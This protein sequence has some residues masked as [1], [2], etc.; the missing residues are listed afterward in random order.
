MKKLFKIASTLFMAAF[1]AA[2][3]ISC[4]LGTH[5]LINPSAGYEEA[6]IA[7]TDI[8]VLTVKYQANVTDTV[9][10]HVDNYSVNIPA[11]ASIEEV[12]AVAKSIC[13][14]VAE[15]FEARTYNRVSGTTYEIGFFRKTVTLT[16]KTSSTATADL[17]TTLKGVY[18]ASF[19]APAKIELPEGREW[20]KWYTPTGSSYLN[21]GEATTFPASS[22]V[23]YPSYYTEKYYVVTYKTEIGTAP[24]PL[25]LKSGSKYPVLTAEQ[26]PVIENPVDDRPFLGWYIDNTKVTAGRTVTSNI[27]LTAKWGNF[28]TVTYIDPSN[29]AQT[30]DVQRVAAGTSLAGLLNP[31]TDP[32]YGFNSTHWTYSNGNKA[33]ES[34]LIYGNITLFANWKNRY[35]L[36]YESKY[37]E[38]PG[39]KV[40]EQGYKLTAEDLPVLTNPNTGYTNSGW[41]TS[42]SCTTSYAVNTVVS[43]DITLYAKWSEAYV[44]KY[45]TMYG[46]AP[47]SSL[48]EE[49]STLSAAQLPVITD[50]ETGFV[51]VGWVDE[52]GKAVTTATKIYKNIELTAVWK[53][54]YTINYKTNTTMFPD[55]VVNGKIVEDGY[56][57]TYVD[58]PTIERGKYVSIWY[59]DD[60]TSTTR[61]TESSSFTVTSDVEFICRW[62]E[63]YTIS[64]E[65][66]YG[67]AP[68]S[69][70]LPQGDYLSATTLESMTEA[71]TGFKSLYWYNKDDDLKTPVTTSTVITADTVLVAAWKDR[72]TVSYAS[73]YGT[74]PSSFVVESGDALTKQ[75]LPVIELASNPPYFTG[76]YV[77]S[78]QIRS[79]YI[80]TNNI[81]LVANWSFSTVSVNYISEYGAAPVNTFIVPGTVLTSSELPEI[82]S[83]GYYFAGW[84]D[85]DDKLAIPDEYVLTQ[86]TTFKAKWSRRGAKAT[87]PANSSYTLDI[88]LNYGIPYIVNVFGE[89]CTISSYSGASYTDTLISNKKYVVAKT[90]NSSGEWINSYT[91]YNNSSEDQVVV[92]YADYDVENTEGPIEITATSA[93]YDQED[94]FEAVT[95]SYNHYRVAY[96]MFVEAGSVLYIQ[97]YDSF[98]T[99]S[100]LGSV[101]WA[102]MYIYIYDADTGV[103]ISSKDDG[104][105]GV[106]L[107][108]TTSKLLF[109]VGGRNNAC[110]S[111]FHPYIQ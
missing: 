5:F 28:Y 3:A 83:E 55:V 91:V 72:F 88:V 80:V 41:Y 79:G 10:T 4:D 9:L 111:Y 92:L 65:T 62:L 86:P 78:E 54:R 17:V 18:G 67:M 8:K 70:I 75:Q 44:V 11:G 6:D 101:N 40:V 100:S 43:S 74:V 109:V 21:A 98:N 69:F 61:I 87:I 25:T 108:N 97:W 34:D 52:N 96:E 103:L 76:W 24:D 19:T 27:T 82:T 20:Y 32:A 38:K 15:G 45:K 99:L 30:P 106:S 102:D 35:T 58:L 105:F 37:G 29:Y 66:D 59:Y 26:L 63:L 56:V 104:N 71:S 94:L 23:Y 14:E 73:A 22:R 49:G 1:L 90:G 95:G 60:G 85:E 68:S 46:K 93:S 2:M 36:H 57:I 50:P 31:L 64:Y 107:P 53:Q 84:F 13:P 12:E 7:V 110:T 33:T 47:E 16:F 48:I 77:N 89:N 81:T 42:P 39:N 51:S